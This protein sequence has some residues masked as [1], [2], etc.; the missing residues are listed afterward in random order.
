MTLPDNMK[1]RVGS[2][3]ESEMIQKA[4]FELG[5]EWEFVGSTR[6]QHKDKPYLYGIRGFQGEK[7]IKYGG[8]YADELFEARSPKLC[9]LEMVPTIVPVEEKTL[10]INGLSYL[11]S[12]IE[13]ALSSIHPVN[14]QSK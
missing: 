5:Y 13:K 2:P 1:F 10:T 6:Y 9:K 12:D 14:T 11:V 7:L 8:K 4:L 3:E